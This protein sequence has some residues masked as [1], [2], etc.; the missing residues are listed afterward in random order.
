MPRP[1]RTDLR[2]NLALAGCTLLLL[3]DLAFERGSPLEAALAT[4]AFLP[5]SL[6]LVSA[7][8]YRYEIAGGIG[9]VL[10]I[11]ALLAASSAHIDIPTI[12]TE[13][14]LGAAL[15]YIR[16]S[17]TLRERRFRA[18]T[19]NATDLILVLDRRGWASYA[20]HSFTALLGCEPG[21]LLANGYRKMFEP[22]SCALLLA[23][24]DRAAGGTT[25]PQRFELEV[26]HRDGSSHVL[27]ATAT[28]ALADPAVRGLILNARD[29]SERRWVEAQLAS[30]TSHDALTGLP[31]R[32]L[33][34][35]RLQN[36]L[37]HATRE[38]SR[39][40]LLLIDLDRFKDVNDAL[41]HQMGDALLCEVANRLR[42]Y[43]R[44]TDFAARLGA[45]EFAVVIAGTD[46]DDANVIAERLITSLCRPYNVRTQTIAVTASVGIA[47]GEG[48]SS[49]ASLLRQADVAMYSAKRR[50]SGIAIFTRH[51]DDRALDRLKMASALPSAIAN[52]E[53]VLHYQPQI[54]VPSGAVNGVEAL[55]RWQHPE[56]G[57]LYPDLFLPLAEEIGMM[58]R[59]TDW[60]LRVAI[61]QLKRWNHSGSKLRMAVNLSGQ[62]LRDGHL[63]ESIS[64]LVSLYGIAARQLCLELSE[65]AVTNESERAAASLR[66]LSGLGIRISID[67]FGTGYSS[68]AHLKQ[69]PVDELKIDKQFVIGMATDLDDAAIVSSTIDLAHRLGVDVVVEGV[70]DDAAF[71]T[72]AHLGADFAQGYGI[73]RPMPAKAFEGWL[74]EYRGYDVTRA[75]TA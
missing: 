55:V 34:H 4:A 67:D 29:I 71:D 21:D 2:R 40:A 48:D 30:Q 46:V 60:V 1:A 61:R 15:G 64:R 26:T 70:E 45:D 22:R 8:A 32:S 58:D 59:L 57:L 56:R 9:A 51:D 53:L 17:A 16:I 10:A 6:L 41:G 47:L 11:V 74:R 50:R 14:I 36:A 42:R 62:D 35:S 3:F 37:A 75:A 24:V 12:G 49:A 18:L 66:D 28:S 73:G 23:A 39:V 13:A 27:D 72:I 52:D 5:C 19:D 7:A 20:S 65:T 31:N 69:F 25:A 54:H 63:S 38:T 44:D 68:L 33:L 43:V